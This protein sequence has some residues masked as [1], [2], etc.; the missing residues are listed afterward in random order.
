[1]SLP[2]IVGVSGYAQHGKDSVADV[3]VETEGYTKVGFSYKMKEALVELNPSIPGMMHLND[4]VRK[5]GWEGAKRSVEVRRLLQVFGSTLRELVGED[6]WIEAL[7]R[8]VKGIYGPGP[9]APKI[10]IPDVRFTNEAQWIRLV[11]G[12]IWKVTRPNFDSGVSN[13]DK[14]EREVPIINAD[15]YFVNDLDLEYLQGN[16][17]R[18][19]ESLNTFGE[20]Y[21]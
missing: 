9:Y 13:D 21:G 20:M 19:V 15:E 4:L 16:V 8:S 5:E 14:T 1:M 18:Y 11:G 12:A 17:K 7:A 10:V 2:R 3:L 6:V